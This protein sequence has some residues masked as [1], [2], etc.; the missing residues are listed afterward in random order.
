MSM[1]PSS[2]KP[3]ESLQIEVENPPNIQSENRAKWAV[4]TSAVVNVA[5]FAAKL[6]A[7]IVSG[8]Q[9]ILASLA[10]SGVDLLSQFVVFVCNTKTRRIDKK[11]PIGKTRL[12]TVG[13]L[14]IACVMTFA[15]VLVIQS[16]IEDLIEGIGSDN[17]PVPKIDVPVYAIVSIAIFLKAILFVYCYLNRTASDAILVLAQDH[18]NDIISN[19]V[20]IIT[21]GVA[22]SFDQKYWYV[23]PIG[24]ICISLFIILCWIILADKQIAKIVGLGAPQDFRDKIHQIA[25]QHDGMMEVDVIR[26]YHLGLRYFVELD[27]VM[28]GDIKLMY[29]HDSALELQKKVEALSEV[30]RAFVHV[31]YAKRESPEHKLDW[32][33]S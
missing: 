25:S 10:D 30:E 23:D 26:A 22:S 13:A 5:L 15:S 33:M 24:G 3:M 19:T 6:F 17:P 32:S 2:S 14:I 4:Q 27:V 11:Y 9:A 8:S 29:I 21:A 12:E 31:D 18:K 28:P 7:F 20:V 16:S 1:E